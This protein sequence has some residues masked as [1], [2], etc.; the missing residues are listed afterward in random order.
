MPLTSVQTNKRL[1]K[2]L[3]FFGYVYGILSY[4]ANEFKEIRRTGSAW[5]P[6]PEGEL[7]TVHLRS[8]QAYL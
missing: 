7:T 5:N 1:I 4:F 2:V 3:K 8:Q 6:V